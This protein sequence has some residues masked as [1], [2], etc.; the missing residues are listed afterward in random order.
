M[1]KN[2]T[3]FKDTNA[4]TSSC[5]WHGC[6]CEG[7]FPAPKSPENRSER[8]YFCLQHI[9]EYNNSWDFFRK[10]DMD[11]VQIDKFQ[12]DNIT[13]HRP[14]WKFGVNGLNFVSIEDLQSQVFLDFRGTHKQLG[15]TGA[16]SKEAITLPKQARDALK[17]LGVRYPITLQEIKK[18]YKTLAKEYHPDLN[19]NAKDEKIK[20]I[21]QAYSYLKGLSIFKS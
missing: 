15:K 3:N 19:N 12:R 13:G 9:R 6:V 20:S 11:L 7:K 21:N 18:R 10:M 4:T 2:A 14:T 5:C 16:S 17:I 8:Y 1:D